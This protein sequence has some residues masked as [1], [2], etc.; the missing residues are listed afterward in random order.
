MRKDRHLW[1]TFNPAEGDPREVIIDQEKDVRICDG[2][3]VVKVRFEK[4]A[5]KWRI[6][7][8]LVDDVFVY[9]GQASP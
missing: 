9:P 1:V 6:K 4:V 7:D 5:Q 3:H 8:V 2:Q